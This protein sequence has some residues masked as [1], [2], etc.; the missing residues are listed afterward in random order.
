MEILELGDDVG[1][2]ID[3]SIVEPGYPHM[4]C[5]STARAGSLAAMA[6]GFRFKLAKRRAGA[7]A[8]TTSRAAT[9]G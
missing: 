7:P 8:R 9:Q 6:L 3:R 1:R 4:A 2:L 5:R